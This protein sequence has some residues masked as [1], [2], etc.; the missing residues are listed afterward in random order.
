MRNQIR[1]LVIFLIILGISACS[2]KPK[3]GVDVPIRIMPLGDSITEG[4]CDAPG[5]CYLPYIQTPVSGGTASSGLEACSWAAN[6]LN[7]ELVSY[8]ASLRDKMVA[9]GFQITYVGSITVTEGLA[10]EGHGG[11]TIA[12]LDFCIQNA[13]WLQEAQPDMIL[14]HIGTNDAGWDH[15]P[16]SMASDLSLLLDHIY[17]I[18]PETTYVIVAQITPVNSGLQAGYVMLHTLANNI[19]AQYN[20]GIPELVNQ[21]HASGKNISYVDMSVAIRSDSDLYDGIHPDRDAQERIADIW[22][23]KIT[24]ILKGQ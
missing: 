17:G 1:T 23:S 18:L 4:L 24:E 6:L 7:P 12:D 15:S 2:P 10:H 21:F 5:N 16:D 3:L 11:Y 14:L 9:E 20:A 19:I 22:L 8:R 13:D